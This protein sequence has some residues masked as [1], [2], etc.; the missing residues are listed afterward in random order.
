MT[1]D[2][3]SFDLFDLPESY[4]ESPWPYFRA[5]RDDDPIHANRDGSVLVTRHED[6]WAVW[7]HP[8]G[9]VDKSE[10]FARRFGA[11]ALLEHHTTS[12]LFRD[13]PDHDRIRATLKPFFDAKALGRLQDRVD[14]IAD[15]LVAAALERGEIELVHEVA[16]EMPLRMMCHLLGFPVE[17]RPTLHRLGGRILYPL[18]PNVAEPDVRAGHEAAAEFR[19]YLVAIIS[20]ASADPDADTVV[21]CLAHHVRAGNVSMEEAAHLSIVLFNGGHETTTNLVAVGLHELLAQPAELRRWRDGPEHDATAVDELIRYVSP[22]QLQGRRLAS[23][24]EL[25]AGTLPTGSEVVISQASA[26]RDERRFDQPDRI[27]V[28]RRPNH[29]IAF[30]AGVHLCIGR[31]LAR[32]EATALLPRLLRAADI[33]RAGPAVFN[34][35]AR[36]RGLAKLPVRLTARRRS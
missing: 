9:M 13:P 35:N 10:Q 23:P 18:N 17:D 32:M 33:E 5:L 21:G 28:G 20:S 1:A 15:E 22:L 34:R 31:V 27:D 36:F 19:D 16:R 26:N 6:V 2:G 4:Y 7:R 11:G 3:R 14:R 25:S 29:H 30:G 12:M 8:G 24:L